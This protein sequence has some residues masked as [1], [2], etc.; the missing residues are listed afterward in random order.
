MGGGASAKTSR[1]DTH[2]QHREIV[3][4]ERIAGSLGLFLEEGN[5]MR[6]RRA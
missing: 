2:P 3:S 5:A 1:P 4:V 6:R